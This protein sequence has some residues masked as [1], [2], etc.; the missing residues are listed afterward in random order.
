MGVTAV[1]LEEGRRVL[2]L[3]GQG[4]KVSRLDVGFPAVRPVTQSR[5]DEDGE[6]DTTALYGAA[7]VSMD[8]M[9]IPGA[10]TLTALVDEL[11]SFCHPASRPY[12]VVERD[13]QQ[14]RM[15][16]R[17]DQQSA[18]ITTPLYQH[19]QA[20]WRAP[21]GV[22]EA[23]TEQIGTSDAVT[24]GSGGRTY[25]RT[26]S[27][28]YAASSPVGAVTVTNDGTVPVRPVLRLY[29]P[30]TD[31]RVENQSTGERLIFTG[32]SLLAGDWLEIDCREKTARLN[33][34]VSQSRLSRLDF[35]NST[36]L[37]LLRG[38]NT[39]RYYPVSFGDG[40]RL[41]VRFR[42]AYL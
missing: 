33:G 39:V 3:R 14:R 30:A 36:Y 34:L 17:V 37:R 27:L 38:M 8:L 15:R 7:A 19:V 25:P 29:G 16:L 26:Y 13:G 20:Q 42:P 4:Y 1:R 31:P 41:E 28:S 21:D 5:P 35:A 24:A 11:R 22:W 10:L 12:L 23:L 32:L 6:L 40:A 18:P 2:D 9:L